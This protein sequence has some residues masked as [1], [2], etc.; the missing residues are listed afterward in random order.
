MSILAAFTSVDLIISMLTIN[1]VDCIY[2][3]QINTDGLTMTFICW[4]LDSRTTFRFFFMRALATSS[5]CT[6][7]FYAQQYK[8][9]YLRILPSPFNGAALALAAAA[10]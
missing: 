7:P 8:Y 2:K 3:A 4:F 5:I 1:I 6:K 10:I 9:T